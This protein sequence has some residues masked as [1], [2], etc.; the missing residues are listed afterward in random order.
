MGVVQ[1][2]L[3]DGENALVGEEKLLDRALG[4]CMS[5]VRGIARELGAIVGCDAALVVARP[6]QLLCGVESECRDGC[7]CMV[8]PGRGY[9]RNG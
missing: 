3:G 4:G 6:E 8:R 2:L 5:A 9:L 1:A 7:G